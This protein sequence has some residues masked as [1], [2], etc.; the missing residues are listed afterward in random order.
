M[1]VVISPVGT[2]VVERVVTAVVDVVTS[3]WG[4]NVVV[5]VTSAISE[6]AVDVVRANLVGVGVVLSNVGVGV[7]PSDIYAGVDVVPSNTDV[8]VVL[9]DIAPG[10]VDV[11]V[12]GVVIDAG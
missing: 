7:V 8:G 5:V 6:I 1:V 3:S 11:I 12:D 2:G 4:D 9:S 10:R